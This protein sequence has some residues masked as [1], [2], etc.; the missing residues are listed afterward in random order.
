M[1]RLSVVLLVLTLASLGLGCGG[2]E[3]PVEQAEEGEG[4]EEVAPAP[5]TTEA[6]AAPIVI[7]NFNCAS[8]DTREDAQARLDE[9]SGKIAVSVRRVLDANDNGVA[10]DEEGS[11]VGADAQNADAGPSPRERDMIGLAN[12]QFA[13]AQAS[14][15][16]EQF[17]TFQ[18]E[19]T[20]ELIAAIEQDI[21]T[22]VQTIL[23]E[24]GYTCDGTAEE[25]LSEE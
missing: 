1:K 11:N 19:V 23:L 20:N 13:E 18:E 22:N 24:R 3:T 2:G 21:D 8:F 16:P 7:V 4:V 5:E 10:C 14:M 15:T 17:A 25:V 12:C 9:A 6:E